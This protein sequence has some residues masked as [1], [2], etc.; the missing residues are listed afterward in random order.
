MAMEGTRIITG[1]PGSRFDWDYIIKFNFDQWSHLL[2]DV[3]VAFETDK[4]PVSIFYDSEDCQSV[5][6][7]MEEAQA[8]I[9]GGFPEQNS[10]LQS[11]LSKIQSVLDKSNEYFIRLST[12][13]PKDVQGGMT[14][15]S[16]ASGILDTLM[17][18]ERAYEDLT[19]YVFHCQQGKSSSMQV[20]LLPWIEIMHGKE[21]RCFVFEN[22]VVAC[23]QT[24]LDRKFKPAS[25]LPIGLAHIKLVVK[26]LTNLIPW[27]TYVIDIEVDEKKARVIEFNPFWKFGSTSAVLFDWVEDR[28][29]LEG[30]KEG[31]CVRWLEGVG[32]GRDKEVWLDV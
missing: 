19:D 8:I 32:M 2:F 6:L 10:V 23:C 11:L 20:H 14:P 28:D 25:F 29:I 24:F 3:R 7:T 30:K 15:Q 1:G 17:R 22:N 16:T 21:T 5:D 31:T 4:E 13:S 9:Q 27:S 12:R 18:S 26:T